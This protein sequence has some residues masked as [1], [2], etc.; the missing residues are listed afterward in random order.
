MATMKAHSFLVAFPYSVLVRTRGYLEPSNSSSSLSSDEDCFVFSVDIAETG[1]PSRRRTFGWSS[2]RK[3]IFRSTDDNPTDENRLDSNVSNSASGGDETILTPTSPLLTALA[4]TNTFKNRTWLPPPVL[5][6]VGAVAN[7]LAVN[8]AVGELDQLNHAPTH[9]EDI[10]MSDENPNVH[11]AEGTSVATQDHSSTDGLADVAAVFPDNSNEEMEGDNPD[12]TSPD[13]IQDF[14]AIRSDSQVDN[15]PDKGTTLEPPSP[16]TDVDMQDV[17]P[18]QTNTEQPLVETIETNPSQTSQPEV[19]KFKLSLDLVD[20]IRGMY[21]ILDLVSEQGSGGLVDKIVISQ[22]HLG[23]F[24]NDVAPKSYTSMTKVDFVALDQAFIRPVGL[25]GSRSEIVRF[26]RDIQAIDDAI[27]SALSVDSTEN[28]QSIPTLR[29]GLYLLSSPQQP[30]VYALYWPEET[31]WNDDAVSSVRRNRITFMRY[32]TKIADQIVALISD[33][34]ANAIVWNTNDETGADNEEDENESDRLFNFEVEKTLEQ[35]ENVTSRAGISVDL[36]NIKQPHLKDAG[37]DPS[38]LIPRLVYGETSI[39]YMS[40]EYIPAYNASRPFSDSYTSFRLKQSLE[41]DSLRLSE[42]LS[43][44]ALEAILPH[45][46]RRAPDPVQHLRRQRQEVGK[47]QENIR[48]EEITKIQQ[49][50]SRDNPTLVRAI[51]LSIVESLVS[52]FSVLNMDR[53]RLLDNNSSRTIGPESEPA[54]ADQTEQID[55]AAANVE[56]LKDADEL[57]REFLDNLVTLHPSAKSLIQTACNDTKAFE[58]ISKLPFTRLKEKLVV[59]HE[60]LPSTAE[61]ERDALITDILSKDLRQEDRDESGVF[62]NVKSKL[63][64]IF[65][66]QPIFNTYNPESKHA[67][68]APKYLRGLKEAVKKVSDLEFLGLVHELVARYPGQTQLIDAAQQVVNHAYQYFVNAIKKRS[69][70]VSNKV[71]GIVLEA[72]KRQLDLEFSSRVQAVRDQSRK[73]FLRAVRDMFVVDPRRVLV[74]QAIEQRASTAW[75]ASAYDSATY[76]ISGMKEQQIEAGLK[77]S[78]SGFHLREE[79]INEMRFNPSHV[80]SLKVHAQL[81]FD[82]KLPMGHTLIYLRLIDENRCLLVVETVGGAIKIFLAPHNDLG[83]DVENNAPKRTLYKEKIGGDFL[84]TYDETKRFLA[85]CGSEKLSLH[86]FAVDES[87]TRLE[88]LGGNVDLKAWYSQ[89]EARIL[90]AV[91]VCGSSEELALVDDSSS[92][93]IYSLTTQQFRPGTLKLP[94]VPLSIHSSPDGACLFVVEEHEQGIYLRAYHWSNL[95]STNGICLE[96][97]N[98]VSKSIFTTSIGGRTKV[99]IVGLDSTT[100][101]CKSLALD[102]TRKATEFCFKEMLAPRSRQDAPHQTSHNCLVN[103]YADVWTRFPVV[104]AVRRQTTP[105]S[106]RSPKCIQFISSLNT[107]PYQTHFSDLITTFERATRKPTDNELSSIDIKSLSYDAFMTANIDDV[108][109]FHAGEWLVDI[110]CLIPIHIAITR[111]NRFIPLKDGVWSTDVERSFL[112]AK[113]DQIVNGLSFGWYESVFQSYMANKPVRVVSSMGEQSVGKSFALNHLVDTSFAGS[114]MR[115]T[116]GVWMSVTPTNDSLIVALDFEGVHSIERS[117]QEDT[118][119]VLFNTA[120]SNLVLFRNNFALSRDIT[121]LFQ[122]F[123]SSTTVLDPAAN[124][125]LFK[126]TLVIIIKDVVDS[127][128]NE[129]TKEF[130]LKFQKI[131]ELEQG[132]NFITK[133]HGGKLAI[134]PWPVIESKQFYTLFPALKRMLDKQSVTHEKAGLFLQTMK[135]LMAKLKVNDWG[136]LDQNLASHRAQ[137]LTTYLPRV[138]EFGAMELEPN[139]EPLKEFDTGLIIEMP[140]S[141]ARFCI[142]TSPA[143]SEQEEHLK[144]LIKSWDQVADR[145]NHSDQEWVQDL[146]SYIDQ[147]FIFRVEHVREWLNVNSARFSTDS[148]QFEAIRR[149]FDNMVIATKANSRLCKLQ[150]SSCQLLCLRVQHHSGDHQCRTSHKCPQ[151][152]SFNDDHGHPIDPCGLP[153]GHSGNHICDISAH[154]CGEPCHLSG[155]RGCLG[156]CSKM[157]NHT[158]TLHECPSTSHECGEP[159]GLSGIRL[160]NGKFY[161]CTERCHKPSNEK[162]DIHLLIS[163]VKHIL[164]EYSVSQREYVKLRLLH[165]QSKQLSLVYM[166]R[167]NIRRLLCVIPIAAGELSHPG[168]H[169][170]KMG[171]NVFHYCETRCQQCGYFCTLPLGHS[172]QEHDTSHGSMSRTRW[173]VEGPEGTVIEVDGHKFGAS[174]NGAP[175]LC[176]MIDF[177]CHVHRPKYFITHTL[178]WRRSGF[179]DPYSQEDRVTFAKCDSMCAGQEHLA[180]ANR[181]PQPSYCDL[182]LFHAPLAQGQAPPVQMQQAYHVMF[183][184]DRSGSMSGND[185]RPLA[186][187]PVTHQIVVA[188]DNRL[189]AVYSSLFAFWSARQAAMNAGNSQVNNRRDAYSI[190]LFDSSATIV[191]E[192]DFTRTPQNLLQQS[193]MERNWSTERTPI[194]IFLSDGEC[195]VDHTIVSGLC[196]RSI[197]L[198]RA[199]SFHSVSFGPSN[200]VLRSMATTATNIEQGAPNDPMHPI[201]PS[202]YTEALDTIRLAETFLGIANSLQKPRGSLMHN[203]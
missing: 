88:G 157:V 164:A 78:I 95:G 90:H 103:C 105:T 187:T 10:I 35:D 196:R 59:I 63:I 1:P 185:R 51:H 123:Q 142:N 181:N 102:I 19:H 17:A 68:E 107:A 8:D 70:E 67:K 112:G 116:E 128:K 179:K 41:K 146:N 56:S 150:C 163:V 166:R 33:E 92:V 60:V 129:I 76:K 155:K 79:D 22:E 144:T 98:L 127:D 125:S 71:E 145:F 198:G 12:S 200:Q 147:L 126:S 100:N 151:V 108:S 72:Y 43:N 49:Q 110:L 36:S 176:S 62:A 201:V 65:T 148:A 168:K 86:V 84:I 135:T 124:P 192:N 94:K 117:A 85:I 93:R 154:L 122:S 159:C 161:S 87:F 9:N 66:P 137:Q 11:I 38:L 32:L 119:L 44:K 106:R 182:P 61:E 114:A 83:R 31:T 193:M 77:Y 18:P 74:M 199:L 109:T 6:L 28:G 82:F 139:F 140:D 14:D 89:Q 171:D 158:D 34:H 191:L 195:G 131:V 58:S 132:S 75:G 169:V 136:S 26:L 69:N 143:P 113:I 101:C 20:S 186:N 48:R 29:S 15:N 184:I 174:D 189:G 3:F 133:L 13:E 115:T 81:H 202:S 16:Q 57:S 149:T 73:E 138:L 173:V 97:P 5:P 30:I 188:H 160:P 111:E 2:V 96:L 52:K 178:H 24:M 175:M 27:A 156:H 177:K 130:S 153:A 194:I 190:V 170:H 203:Y 165:T 45:L 91:F 21:R 104:P 39:G 118:L 4:S 47:E 162:H 7:P 55:N 25:Y 197:A 180:D 80:P 46:E 42:S 172:Q 183:V 37:V 64:Q 54:E 141:H 40:V 152:C 121:G 23:R 120:M 167:F 99:H 134:I 53:S 50:L